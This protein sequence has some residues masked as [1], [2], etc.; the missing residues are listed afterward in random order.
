MIITKSNKN[1]S[2]KKYVFALANLQTHYDDLSSVFFRVSD[3]IIAL[4]RTTC[5]ITLKPVL[6]TRLN[7]W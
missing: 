2:G 4:S 7:L 3:H 5:D 6:S 1:V